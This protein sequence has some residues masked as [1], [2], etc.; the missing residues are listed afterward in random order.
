MGRWAKHALDKEYL[1]FLVSPSIDYMFPGNGPLLL[2][3]SPCREIADF[4]RCLS[5]PFSTA[6]NSSSSSLPFRENLALKHRKAK[7]KN[8][9]SRLQ[10]AGCH[11]KG[12]FQK[13]LHPEAP[14][15]IYNDHIIPLVLVQLNFFC[16]NILCHIFYLLLQIKPQLL[17]TLPS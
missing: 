9:W 7:A 15:F 12:V 13:I 5:W 4:A 16:F 17:G 14:V 8:W 11:E 1:Y 10:K 3:N 6:N 2:L